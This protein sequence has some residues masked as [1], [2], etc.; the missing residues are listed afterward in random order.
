MPGHSVATV[1]VE[2]R[3]HEMKL[4]IRTLVARETRTQEPAGFGD[5]VSGEWFFDLHSFRVLSSR[6]NHGAARESGN[7]GSCD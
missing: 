6:P 2:L 5:A 3:R 7:G 4:H 1:I